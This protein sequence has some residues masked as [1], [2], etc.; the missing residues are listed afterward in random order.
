MGTI[1]AVVPLTFLL[2]KPVFGFIADYFY[3]KRKFIFMSL[4]MSMSLFYLGLYFVPPLNIEV[5]YSFLENNHSRINFC[6]N[7]QP[8]SILA[9]KHF[10]DIIL[11]A[12]E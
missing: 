7:S 11:V 10:N 12:K 8:V 3:E 4:I 6:D 5:D 1:T 9:L 2:A